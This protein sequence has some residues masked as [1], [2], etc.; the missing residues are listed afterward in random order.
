MVICL[1]DGSRIFELTFSLFSRAIAENF[2]LVE[3][4]PAGEIKVSMNCFVYAAYLASI[5]VKQKTHSSLDTCDI[6]GPLIVQ[7]FEVLT[8]IVIISP[9]GAKHSRVSKWL[10]CVVFELVLAPA[11]CS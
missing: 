5:H 7:T 9:C 2:A 4:A 3:K 1:R 8:A 6:A 10:V 11:S